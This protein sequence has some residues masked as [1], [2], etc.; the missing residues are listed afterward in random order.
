MAIILR[1]IIFI[2]FY[3]IIIEFSNSPEVLLILYK[4]VRIFVLATTYF[5]SDPDS[6]EMEKKTIKKCVKSEHS[7]VLCRS[8]L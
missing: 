3:L 6:D 8:P 2:N 5:I 1:A 4:A 7:V